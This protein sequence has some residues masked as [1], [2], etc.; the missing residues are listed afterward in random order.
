MLQS[1]K[2]YARKFD[3]PR[4]FSR[5]ILST[6][7]EIILSLPPQIRTMYTR[8]ALQLSVCNLGKSYSYFIIYHWVGELYN[9]K[10]GLLSCRSKHYV[11]CGGILRWVVIIKAKVIIVI[12]V[13]VTMIVTSVLVRLFHLRATKILGG[14][15][16]QYLFL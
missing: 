10:I 6:C 5:V 12:V 9:I 15:M 1:A 7:Y 3:I 11:S 14:K 4:W 2:N 8:S 16:M 13:T